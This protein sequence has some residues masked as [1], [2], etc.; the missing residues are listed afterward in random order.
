MIS[1]ITKIK[2]K[3]KSNK[4]L[5]FLIIAIIALLLLGIS[6]IYLVLKYHKKDPKEEESIEHK[7]KVEKVMKVFKPSFKINSKTNELTQILFKSIKQYITLSDGTE[8]SYS[9]YA[10]SKYD[11][12]I[13][14]E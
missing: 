14:N 10:K 8:S 11:I 1:P 2:L 7:I 13:L 6:I 3:P 5:L 12:Y 4:C 9:I